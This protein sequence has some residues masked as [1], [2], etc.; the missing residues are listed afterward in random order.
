[1]PGSRTRSIGLF[2][3]GLM[4]AALPV[5]GVTASEAEVAQRAPASSG[6]P[7]PE[8]A[9]ALRPS[10]TSLGASLA[11]GAE[12]LR[13][14]ISRALDEAAAAAA[15]PSA[16]SAGSDG[17]LTVLLLGSDYRTGYRYAEHT[18]VIMVASLDLA[19]KRLAM[20]SIPR[21]VAYFPVHPDNRSGTAKDSGALRVNLLYDRYKRQADGVIERTALDKF[22]KDVAFA[23]G[24]EIDYYAYLRFSGFDALMDN[25]G[26][27]S[28]DIPARIVDPKYQDSASPPFGIQ[29]PTASGWKL[30]GWAAKRCSGT[31]MNC[32]RGIV[33]V[34]SRKGTVGSAANSD[35]Q[36]V[37]RQQGLVLAA[38]RKVASGGADLSSLRSA[39][40]SHVTTSLPTGWEDVSWLRSK[41]AGAIAYS[42]DRIV[43]VPPSYAKVLTY[44]KYSSKL[45]KKAVRGWVDSH[46]E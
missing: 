38:I 31:A 37:R 14:D 24:L 19:T 43:F 42:S 6:S 28:V 15:S 39:S 17:R 11:R 30:R 20:A 8:D 10:G 33:Y 22:R 36:R 23:L 13:S 1:M 44:P 27:V 3:A 45:K 4:V 34:R 18:D 35:A 25:V 26:G 40:L 2:L 29:F 21:D 12:A 16:V 46:M 32:K 7:L 5:M 9:L 41:L